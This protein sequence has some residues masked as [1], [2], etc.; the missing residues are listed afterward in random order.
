MRAGHVAVLVAVYVGPR[1]AWVAFVVWFLAV[2]LA[3]R[4]KIDAELF[5]VLANAPP[6]QLDLWLEEAGLRAKPAISRS[7]AE[8]RKGALRLWR[9]LLTAVIVECIAVFLL[10]LAAYFK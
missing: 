10:L 3:M 8:R 7:I 9:A 5:A 2:Y 4:V 6:A 1:H